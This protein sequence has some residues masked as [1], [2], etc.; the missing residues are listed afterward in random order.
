MWQQE[1]EETLKLFFVSAMYKLNSLEWSSKNSKQKWHL[2]Q[3][4]YRISI[5][6]ATSSCIS[7][8]CWLCFHRPQVDG[9][10]KILPFEDGDPDS[11]P[12]SQK[13][14]GSLHSNKSE[15]YHTDDIHCCDPWRLAIHITAEGPLI[16]IN[17]DQ[18][19]QLWKENR[20]LRFKL[21]KMELHKHQYVHQENHNS[22]C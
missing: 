9:T 7:Y 12:S 2:T 19:I 20:N 22:C 16:T 11:K 14:D 4:T 6:L 1:E 5:C 8:N 3:T 15:A 13:K 21:Q 10:K 17:K 18:P